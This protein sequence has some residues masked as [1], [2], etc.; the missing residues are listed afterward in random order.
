VHAFRRILT[1]AVVATAVAAAASGTAL[2]DPSQATPPL[3][4]IV[5][6]NCPPLYTGALVPDYNATDPTDELYCFAPTGS[7]PINTKGSCEIPRP[8]G[9]NAGITALEA[10]EEDAEGDYCIDFT[11]SDRPPESTDPTSI[12]F[13]PFAGDAIAWSSPA[14]TSTDPTPVPSTLTLADL[15]SIYECTITNWDQVGGSD[16]PIVPVLPQSGSGTRTTFLLDLGNGTPI[17]P[18]SC[19]VNGSNSTGIIQGDTGLGAANVAQFDP[20]GVPAVDDIF[21]YGIGDFLAQGTETNGVGGH[22]S[23]TWGHGVLE[24]GDLT[25]SSGTVEAPTTTNSSGQPV[26]NTSYPYFQ[27]DL[28]N[29]VRNADT[30]PATA[31]PAYL[32]P[33]FG[34]SDWL[35]TNSIAQADII[36]YGFY[37]LGRNCGSLIDG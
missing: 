3:T 31:I 23:S 24:L 9:S 5:G 7:S 16:A 4:S 6:V 21:P 35:C 11:F 8:D 25:N 30:A 27:R 33:I 19:V 34:S 26:I 28:F 12:V 32:Q 13:V 36:S 22:A 18:G 37:S 2:A 1:L 14:G 10:N 29:V 20:D 17:T 15:Q